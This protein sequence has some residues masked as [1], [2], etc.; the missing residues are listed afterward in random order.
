MP[1]IT[2]QKGGSY[3]YKGKRYDKGV[4]VT[5][6]PAVSQYLLSTGRFVDSGSYVAAGAQKKVNPNRTVIK[7]SD[8]IKED[9]EKKA[10]KVAK[11][12]VLEAKQTA[13]TALV[14][15]FK[16]EL[17]EFQDAKAVRKYAKDEHGIVLL[18]NKQDK[19]IDELAFKLAEAESVEE[20]APAKKQ[21]N[22]KNGIKV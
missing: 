6:S 14:A 21:V 19:M 18:Q 9:K 17:P 13:F 7:L 20:K 10:A 12:S 8:S 11:T 3:S 15:E 16:S 4:K 5:V 2:L 22:K 1:D